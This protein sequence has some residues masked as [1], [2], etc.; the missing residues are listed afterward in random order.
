MLLDVAAREGL[1]R[2][3]GQRLSGRRSPHARGGRGK[4]YRRRRVDHAPRRRHGRDGADARGTAGHGR[5]RDRA[6]EQQPGADAGDRGGR[7]GPHGWRRT[8]SAGRCAARSRRASAPIRKAICARSATWRCSRERTGWTSASARATAST[9]GSSTAA[10]RALRG[11]AVTLLSSVPGLAKE[12]IS[13]SGGAFRFAG[14]A[15]G[16]YQLSAHEGGVLHGPAG[17][18]ALPTAPPTGSSCGFS[19]AAA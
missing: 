14:L 7:L 8:L 15:P 6:A 3:G 16:G 11:V 17:R 18:A 12:E 1:A 4:E 10:G 19:R 9:A 5:A 2:G 13:D